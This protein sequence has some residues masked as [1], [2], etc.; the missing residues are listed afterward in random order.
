MSAILELKKISK[1]YQADQ[2]QT[3]ALKN[4]SLN[5]NEG[6]FVSLMGASGSGKSTL[7]HLLGLLDNPTHGEFNFKNRNVKNLSRKEIIAL[8]KLNVG[9]VFQNFN[10][11]NDLNVYEN[12]EL[13]LVYL[14]IDK[15]TRQQ[16]AHEILER[17]GII[18]KIKSYPQQLS[19]G[20][21]QR[22]AVARAMI[23]KP[24]IILAD[25]PTGNLDTEQGNEVMEMLSEQNEEGTTIVMA[26]HNYND[27]AYAKRIIKM[28]DGELLSENR[29]VN[30]A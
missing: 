19:G 2:V 12:V 30:V 9:F 27:A 11:I 1:V 7:L 10:L 13:P 20:Q 3:V 22:T 14:N 23:T 29:S 8:R 16:K 26:T 24:K 18:H 6:E 21:Q 17:L 28:L 15:K 5:I 4:I 25:E